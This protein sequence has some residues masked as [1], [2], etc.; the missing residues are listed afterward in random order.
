MGSITIRLDDKIKKEMVEICKT[1][2]MT[3]STAF[4]MFA[5]A[6]VQEK[7]MPF[8]VR[9]NIPNAETIAAIKA[10][11]RGETFGPFDSVE[12]LMEA[13]NA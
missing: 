8:P 11:E 2:G 5:H 4:N 9:Q 12:S 6:F 3:P 7:G 13:L 1:L 10:A